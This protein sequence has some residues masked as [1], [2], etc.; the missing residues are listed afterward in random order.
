MTARKGNIGSGRGRNLIAFLA[1]VVLVGGGAA[2][3]IV[4]LPMEVGWATAILIIPLS[5]LIMAV[6]R[7]PYLGILM[8]YFLEYFRPQDIFSAAQ[9]FRLP[10]LATAGMFFVYII[11][12]IRDPQ[13]RV[14]WPQQ[15]TTLLVL[16][17]FMGISVLTSV[18]NYWAFQFF[19]GMILIVVLFFI[20]VNIVDTPSRMRGL[21]NLLIAAHIFLCFKGMSQFFIGNEWGTT[22]SVGGSFLGDENDFALALIII[23]PF[24][25]FRIEESVRKKPK[26]LWGLVAFIILITI[27]MT[28]SR[29]GFVGMTATIFFC[30]LKSKKKL[31]SAVGL[32][33]LIAIV[34]SVT[35]SRYYEEMSTIKNTDEG[36]AHKRREYWM[37]GIRMYAEKPLI[38]VGPGNSALLMPI[39]L[40][41]P[42][43]NTEWGRAMHGTVPLLAAEMG[44]VG[45]A[46]YAIFVLQ[47]MGDLRRMRRKIQPDP[48]SAR[49]IAY[50]GNAT[51]AAFLGFGVTSMFLSALYYPHIYVLASLSAIGWRLARMEAG[52]EA[53]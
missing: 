37:A 6:M 35:P 46:I 39:Y 33:L 49:F 28:M 3:A 53:S 43:A 24:I 51:M 36:T 42:N 10:F 16:L 5:L 20:T 25:F 32:I 29:G 13:K 18:N 8:I 26:I 27:M 38:G 50:L 9:P 48:E 22:G 19:R 30:W 40:D 45:L 21:L 12:F 47:S 41:L 17:L 1:T 14:F 4:N 44:T 52:R 23:F 31:L 7:K 11:T 34:A 15:T 2:Y